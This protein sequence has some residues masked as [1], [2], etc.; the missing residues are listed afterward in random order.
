MLRGRRRA[1]RGGGEGV[2]TAGRAHEGAPRRGPRLPGGAVAPE[3][4]HQRP[5]LLG[6]GIERGRPEGRR[7]VGRQDHRHADRHRLHRRPAELL[8]IIVMRVVRE[9]IQIGQEIAH[10]ARAE[11][12]GPPVD[13]PA[14]DPCPGMRGAAEEARVAGAIGAIGG[15]QA[16]PGALAIS[17]DGRGRAG[18][19]P[20]GRG[21]P[22]ARWARGRTRSRYRSA[23]SRY[24]RAAPDSADRPASPRAPAPRSAPRAPPSPRVRRDAPGR[25]PDHRRYRCARRRVPGCVRPAGSPPPPDAA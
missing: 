9:K 10:V 18:R 23:A 16:R 22:R 8:D 12:L 13:R 11:G 25:G 21:P 14:P 7:E 6:R 17:A 20:G 5:D 3:A 24:R 1:G 15:A 4:F 2:V 19:A